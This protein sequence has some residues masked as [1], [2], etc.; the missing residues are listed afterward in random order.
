M[1]AKHFVSWFC[2]TLFGLGVMTAESGQ[3]PQEYSRL[4]WIQSTGNQYVKID[5]WHTATTRVELACHIPTPTSGG[6]LTMFGSRNDSASSCAYYFSARF[7]G[8][9]CAMFCLTGKEG[10]QNVTTHLYDEDVTIRTDA[11]TK[12]ATWENKWGEGGSVASTGTAGDGLCSWTLFWLNKAKT[13]D[14]LS[15]DDK[16]SVYRFYSMKIYEGE[17]LVC[18]LV[19]AMRHADGVAGVYDL[20]RDRFFANGSPVNPFVVPDAF[21]VELT[22]PQDRS[23]DGIHPLQGVSVRV[24]DIATGKELVEGSDYSVTWD[25][26]SMPG[27]HNVLVAGLSNTDYEGVVKRLQFSTSIMLGARRPYLPSG[28]TEVEWVA[29]TP[30]GNQWVDTG[31]VHTPTTAALCDCFLDS[32]LNTMKYGCIFG[33]RKNTYWYNCYCFFSRFENNN[34]CYARTNGEKRGTPFIFDKRV[35]VSTDGAQAFVTDGVTTNVITTTGTTD[36]GFGPFYLFCHNDT[37]DATERHSD[38]SVARIYSFAMLDGN[39]YSAWLVP[40]CR[41]VDGAIGFYDVTHLAEGDAAFRPNGAGTSLARGGE[42]FRP[43]KADETLD[44]FCTACDATFVDFIY[45]VNDKSLV[46]ASVTLKW[47]DNAEFDDARQQDLGTSA[48]YLEEVSGRVGDLVAGK[49]Y[50]LSLTLGKDGRDSVVR[51]FSVKLPGRAGIIAE[52]VDITWPFGENPVFKGSILSYGAGDVHTVKLCFSTDGETFVE[53]GSTEVTDNGPFSV[54]GVWPAYFQPVKYKLAYITED[55]VSETT[56]KERTATYTATFTWKSDVAE[57]KWADAGNWAM[58]DVSVSNP[59]EDYPCQDG[60]HAVVFPAA[61]TTRVH[62][63]GGESCWHMTVGMNANVTLVGASGGDSSSFATGAFVINSQGFRLVLDHV[64][65][66]LTTTVGPELASPGWLNLGR[67]S[68]IRLQNGSSL[69]SAGNQCPINILSRDAA[70]EVT[71]GSSV[72]I[73]LPGNNDYFRAVGPDSVVLVD[74]SSF[75]CDKWINLNSSGYDWATWRFSGKSPILAA[76]HCRL[77]GKGGARLVFDA[78]REGFA[79]A[80]LEINGDMLMNCAGT[81]EVSVPDDAQ[82]WKGASCDFALIDAPKGINTN[83]VTF[84]TGRRTNGT[85]IWTT[86]DGIANPTGLKFR[87]RNKGLMLI[88]K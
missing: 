19:P 3:M 78:P 8:A 79:H 31:V 26:L 60:Y 5:Y 75:S 28:Y 64:N 61:M 48:G 9:N 58:S 88:L 44:F 14:G 53:A 57:G 46:G 80:P 15:L 38:F 34:S 18:D 30:D 29:S 85:F 21:T 56:V 25:D 49:T 2:L 43:A 84:S 76:Q 35:L 10:R 66:N 65:C 16:G 27:T 40:C 71:G 77:S 32:A 62:L 6:Y 23:V 68:C 22:L 81:V 83:N 13:R 1:K 33:S 67:W 59:P 12:T 7:F 11:A 52:D 63:D 54:S 41:N 24:L 4:A 17:T 87:V 36:E 20:Q 82:V 42:I 55:G 50:Y 47:A 69:T 74:D 51:T 86:T 72:S 37:Y 45:S 70:F 73:A 39:V